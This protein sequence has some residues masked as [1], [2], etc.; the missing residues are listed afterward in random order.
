[1]NLPVVAVQ[2]LART[3]RG[4]RDGVPNQVHNEPFVYSK[5]PKDDGLFEGAARFGRFNAIVAYVFA[6]PGDIALI[7]DRCFME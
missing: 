1:M 6:S 2:R 3:S 5:W 4:N 7:R